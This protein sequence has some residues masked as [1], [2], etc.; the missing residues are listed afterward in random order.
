MTL[1]S[2]LK[3]KAKTVNSDRLKNAAEAKQVIRERKAR[4]AALDLARKIRV[5]KLE[6]N[7]SLNKDY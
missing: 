1:A 4:Q 2:Q 6:K 7:E 5:N 3:Q